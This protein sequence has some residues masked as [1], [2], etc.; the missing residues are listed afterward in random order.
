MVDGK[1]LRVGATKAMFAIVPLFSGALN[2]IAFDYRSRVKQKRLEEFLHQV[3]DRLKDVEARSVREDYLNSEEFGDFLESVLDRAVRTSREKKRER[4]RDVLCRQVTEPADLEFAE[5]FLALATE[6]S[7][8]EMEMLIRFRDAADYL[9][10]QP[11]DDRPSDEEIKR[12]EAHLRPETYGID[13]LDFRF[14]LQ[15]LC[16]RGLFVD[17]S[18][19]R[20]DT[21]SFDIVLITEFGRGFLEFIA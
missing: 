12:R 7:E 16:A 15:H 2:E 21:R 4:L 10:K 5:V 1:E 9:E 13:R 3:A 18:M 11:P 20:F 14:F 8:K 17:D 19:N 6:I